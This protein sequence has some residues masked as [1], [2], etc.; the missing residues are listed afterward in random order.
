MDARNNNKSDN[1][2]RQQGGQKHE[3]VWK[4]KADQPENC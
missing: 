2:K 3:K 4:K 1:N